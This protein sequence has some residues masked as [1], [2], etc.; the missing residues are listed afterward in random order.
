[1][2][3]RSKFPPQSLLV[4]SVL[5]E[6]LASVDRSKVPALLGLALP[7]TTLVAVGYG[8][9]QSTQQLTTLA[10]SKL[11]NCEASDGPVAELLGPDDCSDR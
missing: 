3:I 10:P 8:H 6:D 11:F 4:L 7:H 5:F 9:Q 1:M 2:S